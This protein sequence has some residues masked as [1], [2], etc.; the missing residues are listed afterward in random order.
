VV[1][2]LSRLS[3]KQSSSGGKIYVGALGDRFARQTC[4]LGCCVWS[5]V[6]CRDSTLAPSHFTC[7]TRIEIHQN[8]QIA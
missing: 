6:S 7:K 5:T 1:A 8:M 2:R 4:G 3:S